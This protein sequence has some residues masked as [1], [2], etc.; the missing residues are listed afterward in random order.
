[1]FASTKKAAA[2]Y[3]QVSLDVAIETADP[4]RLILMLFEGASTALATAR[5]AMENND[6]AT[7]GAAISKAIDII[8]NGLDASLDPEQGGELAERLSA[9]YNYMTSRLFWANLKNDLAALKEVQGLLAELQDAWR[10][11]APKAGG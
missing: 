6:L 7:K 8:S 5:Y 2:A 11:I 1:M 4:H 9:L 3:Q 10:Q